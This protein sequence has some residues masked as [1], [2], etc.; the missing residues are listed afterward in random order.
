[1]QIQVPRLVQVL[2]IR[3]VR[4]FDALFQRV[5]C[6]SPPHK[7]S[8]EKAAGTCKLNTAGITFMKRKAALQTENA[9]GSLQGEEFITPSPKHTSV[10]KE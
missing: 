4:L 2:G 1:M 8:M 3:D 10:F 6:F 9:C 5:L 7:T